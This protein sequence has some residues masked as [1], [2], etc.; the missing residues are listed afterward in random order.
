MRSLL[1]KIVRPFRRGGVV[2]ALA[3]LALPVAAGAAP[4]RWSFD[5]A[6]AGLS[7][8]G[9]IVD[10]DGRS[11]AFLP[12]AYLSYSLTSQVSAAAT[13][14]RDFARDLTIGQAG[15]R[16][17]MWGNEHGRIFGGVNAV[18]YGDAGSSTITE[19]TSWNASIHGAWRMAENE[20]QTVLWAITSAAYDS[21][22]R[23]TIYRLGLRWQ[24]IGGHPQ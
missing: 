13:V 2:V 17:R 11:S 9:A 21:E 14:E 6:S 15:L 7:A 18:A 22:N 24:A 8:T 12:G 19:P 10:H 4:A 1:W 3:L 16:F 20:G 23:L 5:R